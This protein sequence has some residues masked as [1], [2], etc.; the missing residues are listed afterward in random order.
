MRQVDLALRAEQLGGAPTT[1]G[2]CADSNFSG[3]HFFWGL[4]MFRVW[5]FQVVGFGVCG[6]SGSHFFWGLGMFRV[7]GFQV[8]GFGVCWWGS[9]LREVFINGNGGDENDHHHRC[10]LSY[11]FLCHC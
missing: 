10:C 5:G 6:F 11:F 1:A 2:S 7:W 3:S 4:G 9:D 8:V